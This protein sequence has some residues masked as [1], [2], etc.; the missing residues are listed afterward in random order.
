MEY[1]VVFVFHMHVLLIHWIALVII[2][3]HLNMQLIG[4]NQMYLSLEI[5]KY[6]LKVFLAI[7]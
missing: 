6:K 5:Y 7:K 4:R 1:T 3:V 2:L